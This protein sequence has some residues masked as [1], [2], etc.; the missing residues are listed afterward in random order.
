VVTAAVRDICERTFAFSVRI[1]KL[2]N[3]LPKTVAAVTIARQLIRCGT[4]VGANVEEARA[5]HSRRD[6]ARRM[7]IARGEARETLYWLRLARDSGL[8]SAARL[9]AI[10]READELVRILTAT[11]KRTKSNG[12][13]STKG[14]N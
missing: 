8:V 1:V 6:F 14:R 3:A 11:V 12:D 4:S 10:I 2:V 13:S 9:S 7:N 5:A